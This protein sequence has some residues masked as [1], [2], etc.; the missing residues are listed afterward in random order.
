MLIFFAEGRVKIG[1]GTIF[2]NLM[3]IVVDEISLSF[4]EIGKKCR[5][6]AEVI[7][8]AHDYSYAVLRS[9]YHCMPKKA[10]VTKIGD[11]VFTGLKSIILLGSQIGNNVLYQEKFQTM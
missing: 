5:I 9:E 6:T 8:L 3:N 1:E 7:I 4:I 2:Y 10:G 11:N